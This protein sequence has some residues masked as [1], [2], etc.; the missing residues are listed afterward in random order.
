MDISADPKEIKWV[1]TEMRSGSLR[2]LPHPMSPP[3]CCLWE[4]FSQKSLLREVRAYRNRGS[5]QRRADNS[6]LI[7][8]QSQGSSAPPQGLQIILRAVSC[9]PSHRYWNPQQAEKW[10]HD[11]QTVAVTW[12]SSGPRTGLKEA[13]TH[14]PWNWRSTVLNKADTAQTSEDQLR[15]CQGWR[16]CFCR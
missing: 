6:S 13:E 8:K 1:I 3:A 2:S 12:A 11:G 7:I 9:E 5:S 4:N 15:D 16:R 10:L 14:Q